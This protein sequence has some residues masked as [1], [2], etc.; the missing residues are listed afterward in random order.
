MRLSNCKFKITAFLSC[1]GF[2]LF[3]CSQND[4]DESNVNYPDRMLIQENNAVPSS[5]NTSADHEQS[6]DTSAESER[7]NH[8]C[9]YEV[10]LN[11]E[12][13][14]NDQLGDSDHKFIHSI[15]EWEQFEPSLSVLLPAYHLEKVNESLQSIDFTSTQLLYIRTTAFSG[16]LSLNIDL[17]CDSSISA[18]LGWCDGQGG[19]TAYHFHSMVLV[20]P[21][22]DYSVSFESPRQID[23]D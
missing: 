14:Y 19:D 15:N 9:K 21:K 22:G 3:A 6:R 8:A 2:L 5:Q 16:G 10:L 13:D 11:I 12:H 4:N 7:I 23:C 20:L 17:A 18:F 1:I